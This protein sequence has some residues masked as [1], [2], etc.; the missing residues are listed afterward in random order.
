MQNLRFSGDVRTTLVTVLRGE[1]SAHRDDQDNAQ[2]LLDELVQSPASEA[3]TPGSSPGRGID[4]NAEINLMNIRSIS[5]HDAMRKRFMTAFW[6]YVGL[7]VLQ[8]GL[9][10]WRL[11]TR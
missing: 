5:A 6:V 10:I 11:F 7:I 3:G 1:D 4:F 8:T 9:I 2:A